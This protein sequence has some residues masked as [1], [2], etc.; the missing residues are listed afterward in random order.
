MLILL[1]SVLNIPV[2][3][4]LMRTEDVFRKKNK[5]I[6][7]DLLAE[8]YFWH[9]GLWPKNMWRRRN[10]RRKGDVELPDT[11][12]RSEHR[13]DTP[14]SLTL[15][16]FLLLLLFC[17]KYMIRH[18]IVWS[19]KKRAAHKLQQSFTQLMAVFLSLSRCLV[20]VS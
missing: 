20:F 9:C 17:F 1:F 6:Q 2:H 12:A 10:W 13:R 8:Y 5:A 3:L 19:I 11:A 16:V 18:V 14:K 4:A 15:S 7:Y